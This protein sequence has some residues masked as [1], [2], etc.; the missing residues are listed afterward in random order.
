MNA[1]VH[2]CALFSIQVVNVLERSA[3]LAMASDGLPFEE[4]IENL[5]SQLP[6]VPML[7]GPS[8]IRK[9]STGMGP[10]PQA[11]MFPPT[12]PAPYQLIILK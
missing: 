8:A 1:G 3:V 5:L 4:E 6:P 7:E 11:V 9:N 10:P 12:F 2:A